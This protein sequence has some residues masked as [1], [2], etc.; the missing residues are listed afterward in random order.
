MD[1]A[2]KPKNEELPIRLLISCDMCRQRKVKCDGL[3]PSC[4]RCSKMNVNC[5]YSPI[6][7]RRR[8]RKI[9]SGL[10]SIDSYQGN[11]SLTEVLDIHKE[12]NELLDRLKNISVN[13]ATL[14]PLP[15]IKEAQENCDFQSNISTPCP[16][17]ND[18]FSE[19]C[20]QFDTEYLDSIFNKID[21]LKAKQYIYS[22]FKSYHSYLTG[23][24]YSSD[25]EL[26][27]LSQF[28]H[29]ASLPLLCAIF[30]GGSLY[31]AKKNEKSQHTEYYTDFKI[32]YNHLKNQ[33]SNILE[34]SSAESI[35]TLNIL[36]IIETK[37]GIEGLYQSLALRLC[38]RLG[39]DKPS[40]PYN[41]NFKSVFWSTLLLDSLSFW[42]NGENPSIDY[43]NIDLNSSTYIG[44]LAL[45]IL[46][47]SKIS[48]S[49][50]LS[51]AGHLLSLSDHSSQALVKLDLW[52]KT[53]PAAV[54]FNKIEIND[55]L[56]LINDGQAEL[57]LASKIFIHSLYHTLVI[58]L[59]RNYTSE[60]WTVNSSL[61]SGSSHNSLLRSMHPICERSIISAGII[62]N[63][64]TLA[65][66]IDSFCQFYGLATCVYIAGLVYVECIK[67]NSLN[68]ATN[69]DLLNKHIDFLKKLGN[70]HLA[71]KLLIQAQIALQ[72]SSIDDFS[73]SSKTNINTLD[74]FL[75]SGAAKFDQNS[76]YN[77]T[78]I[79]LN[80]GINLDTDM[81]SK[82][83]CITT[84]FPIG[85]KETE[86]Q[87][88]FNSNFSDV[89]STVINAEHAEN[90]IFKDL[91]NF[92]SLD[93]A[94]IDEITSCAFSN[95]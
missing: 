65:R 54:S 67:S 94:D 11:T 78:D 59:S 50:S 92:S 36:S 66:N 34:S 28:E 33:I 38:I 85:G 57:Q 45:L 58:I 40:N 12:I 10:K 30:A 53:L 37:L 39:L 41:S 44:N 88:Q 35:I 17:L 49:N 47:T 76:L 22:F 20:D 7:E 46:K 61:E 29:R 18:S 90:Q 74:N 23:F 14:E 5:H 8:T 1:S 86:Y 32:F 42:K 70:K 69:Q 55:Q 13:S 79:N 16:E 21:S 2:S 52:Y 26:Y 84:L 71:E 63:I 87:P 9:P 81:T 77:G 75:T 27:L 31:L 43:T 25:L 62:S 24:Y 80:L 93:K 56:S 83:E 15:T 4:G 64:I 6:T 72:A 60:I 19:N 48:Y 91:M 82:T 3:K 68:N 89:C 73:Q 95:I 51:N